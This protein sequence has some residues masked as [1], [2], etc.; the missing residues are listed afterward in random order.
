MRRRVDTKLGAIELRIW[1][2]RRL[3]A[4]RPATRTPNRRAGCRLCVTNALIIARPIPRRRRR[5]VQAALSG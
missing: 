3:L 2:R 1:A 5:V 4:W